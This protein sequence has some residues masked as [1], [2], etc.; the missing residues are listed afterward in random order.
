MK[1]LYTISAL[2][3][4]SLVLSVN[5]LAAYT[6]AIFPTA[7]ESAATYFTF[8][9]AGT[10]V[11]D[12]MIAY[13]EVT[14]TW[15]NYSFYVGEDNQKTAVSKVQPL[16][17]LGTSASGLFSVNIYTT[18]TY[19]D[20]YYPHSF[21][22]LD[23]T[24][25]IYG[26]ACWI[27]PITEGCVAGQA[28]SAASHIFTGSGAFFK[29]EFVVNE[30]TATFKVLKSADG[31]TWVWD[32]GQ[33]GHPSSGTVLKVGEGLKG[34]GSS[35][36]SLNIPG[37]KSGD[38]VELQLSKDGAIYTLKAYY[39]P[40]PVITQ[41]GDGCNTII[42]KLG[43]YDQTEFTPTFTLNGTA[44]TFT[45]NQ[46][47]V[48]NPVRGKQ[49]TVSGYFTDE[50]GWK[51]E[52]ATL[53][54]M[55]PEQV[56]KPVVEVS[57]DACNVAPVFTLKNP[58][59]GVTYT[60]KLN[61]SVVT[62][63]DNQY[64]VVSPIAGTIYSMEVT[65]TDGC[66]QT[67]SD[68]VSRTYKAAPGAPVVS[69][70]FGCDAPIVFTVTNYDSQN[71]Y[72]WKV[73]NSLVSVSGNSYTVPSPV[74][75]TKY[76]ADVI[77]SK[78]GCDSPSGLA[79]NAYI[80]TPVKPELSTNDGC[81]NDVIFTLTNPDS[82]STY[83]WVSGGVVIP[84]SGNS[85]TVPNPVDGENYT[86]NVTAA[87]SFD[88]FG[89]CPSVKET[90]SQVY[91]AIPA[92]PDVTAYRECATTGTGSWS[93]LVTLKSKHTAVWYD[94]ESSST[95]IPQPADYDKSDVGV[96]SYWV[97]QKSQSGCVS[98]RSKVSVEVLE[99]PVNP[100]TSM[101][102]NCQKEGTQ[103][104]ASLVSATGTLHWYET[105][106][107]TTEIADPGNFDTNVPQTTTYYVTQ[108]NNNGC[109]S[110]KSAVVVVVRQNPAAPKVTDYIA[111]QE[112]G[113]GK[114]A[115]LVK[116][117]QYLTLRWYESET[118]T[119]Y[120]PTANVP[121]FNKNVVGVRSY[122]VSSVS[123][124]GSCESAR[125]KVTVDV[126]Q[127]PSVYAG[128]NRSICYGT[129]TQ[130]GEEVLSPG[131]VKYSWEPV[132]LIV[133][134]TVSNPVT[135][136]LTNTTTFTVTAY[137]QSL[138]TCYATSSVTVTVVEN[139]VADL[140]S[141]S[142]P[143]CPGTSTTF[144]NKATESD[145]SYSWTPTDKIQGSTTGSS[146]ITKSLTETTEFTLTASRKLY[147]SL[148][149]SS[150][151]C[152]STVTGKAYIVEAPEAFAGDDAKVCIGAVHRLGKAGELNVVY[153]WTPA[154]KVDYPNI[155]NPN[156]V[157]VTEDIEYTLTATLAAAPYCSSTDQVKI[158]KVEK[159]NKYVVSG[160]NNYCSSESTAAMIIT[161]SESDMNTE[162]ALFRD[163]VMVKD[164]Q[165]GTGGSFKW[166]DN[167]A[168]VYTVKARIIGTNC[169]EDMDGK[170][171]II[172][173]QSPTATVVNKGVV[174]CPGETTTIQVVFQGDAPF[175]YK[176]SENGVVNHTGTT[177]SQVYE[178]ELTPVGNTVIKVES[179]EDAY[180]KNTFS[181]GD[182]PKLELDIEALADFKI[183][184]TQSASVVCPGDKI[185]LYIDY[186]GGTTHYQWSTGVIDEPSIDVSPT[187]TSQYK[188]YAE[189]ET[190]CIL[191][192]SITV[193]VASKDAFKIEGLRDTRNYCSSETN[194]QITG[195]PTG[196]V[197]SSNKPCI[198]KGT[199]TLDFS[200]VDKSQEVTLT[201]TYGQQGCVFD[202]T[203][204]LHVSAVLTEV[205]WMVVP[206]FGP[207][208][209][210]D[211]TY[212]LKTNEEE[213]N[214]K[215]PLQGYPQQKNGTWKVE[216]NPQTG[217]SSS[218]K[219]IVTDP[220][221][222]QANLV[223]VS[224]G[225]YFITYYVKDEFGCEASKTKNLIIRKDVQEL[226]DM[227]GFVYD[228][229]DIVCNKS[230]S[231]IIKAD[232]ITGTYSMNPS[233]AINE[234]KD[235]V[236]DFN[237]SAFSQG[238]NSAIYTILDNKGCPHRYSAP[239]TV[240]A[241]VNV[242]VNTSKNSYCSYDA[243]DPIT[244]ESLTP[245]TGLISIYRCASG[246][247]CSDDNN[248][249]LVESQIPVFS[250]PQFR[251]TWGS[252]EY[253]I[254]YAYDDGNC[255][256]IAKR[257]VNVYDPTPISM[258]MNYDY[259]KGDVIKLGATPTGGFYT[260]PDA[261]EG[262]II[263]TTFY[264]EKSGLGQFTLT[265]EVIN[266]YQCVSQDT[267]QIL[268]RGTDNL[269][270]F[271]LPD[272]VCSP[273]GSIEIFGFP[274]PEN[275]DSVYFTGPSFLHGHTTPRDSLEYATIDLSKANF[276][277][278]YN[279][280]YNYVQAYIDSLSQ[281][282][283]TCLSTVTE[284]FKV[285]NEASDFGGYEHLSYLCGDKDY[286]EIAANHT[287]N[288]DFIF[289]DVI[290]HPDAF[291]DNGD[292]TGVIYP[293]KL[294]EGMYS[295]TMYHYLVEE[296]QECTDPDDP[297]TCV[298]VYDTVCSTSKAK[299]FYIER[300]LDIPEIGLYCNNG[301]N[302]VKMD[303]TE[304]DVK[305]TLFVNNNYFEEQTGDGGPIYYGE[306]PLDIANC[307]I[308]AYANGC[309]YAM[310]KV[311][312]VEKLKMEHTTKNISCN[313]QIDGQFQATVTGGR[314]PYYHVISDKA[315]SAIVVKDSVDLHLGPQEYTY[316]ITDSVGCVRTTDF[317]ITQPDV[318]TVTI[319]KQD[320]NCTGTSTGILRAMPDGGSIPYTY[321]WVDKATGTVVGTDA[322]LVDVPSGDYQVNIT[323]NNGC[324]A[325][326]TETL[327]APVPLKVKVTNVV[328]VAVIG[329]AT[330][331]IDIVASDGTPTATGE[332]FYKWTGKSITPAT[333]AQQNQTDLLAGNY[334]VT[335]TDDRGCEVSTSA[336][337]TEPTPYV[338]SANIKNVS[339]N[340]GS[341]GYI[342]MNISGVQAP[343][344]YT[345]TINGGQVVGTSKDLLN[346][347]ADIYHL[348]VEDALGNKYENDYQV[349]EPDV[350]QVA[351]TITSNFTE[352]C[353]GDKTANID[354]AI[355][356]GTLPYNVTW[357]GVAPEQITDSAHV[358][359]LAAGTYQVDIVDA[360][361]C[362]TSLS[363][364][365]T[366]PAA[367]LAIASAVVKDLVCY[368][369]ADG[370]IDIEVQ[371]GTAPYTYL[372]TGPGVDPVAEDQT[373]L[374]GGHFGVKITD[375][376]GC[377]IGREFDVFEPSEL[378]VDAYG[379]SLAC[380][381][382][383]KGKV[384]NI[385]EGGV[386]PYSFIW[387]NSAST[388]ISTD[389][390]VISLPAETYTV[391]VTDK[392]GCV[393]HSTTILTQ[394]TELTATTDFTNIQ[395]NGAA[396]GKV[397]VTP[398]GGTEAYKYAWYKLPDETIA[399]S[400][401]SAVTNLEPGSYRA[402]VTDANG[403]SLQTNVLTLTE[404]DALKINYTVDDVAVHGEATGVINASTTGG[405][406]PVEYTWTA[407]PSID[408]TNRHNQT[409]TGIL[410]GNYYLDVKDANGCTNSEMIVVN[411]PEALDVT[412]VVEN[413][414]CN[415]SSTGAIVVSVEGGDGNYSYTWTSDKGYTATTKDIVGVPAD[416]YYVTVT[417][418][419]GATVNKE[420]D[421]TEPDLLKS[422]MVT[423]GTNLTVK[424][425][426]EK[427]AT[428]K[429][430]FSGGTAPYKVTWNGPD[431]PASVAD[432]SFVS[433]LGTG[434][435]TMK[436]EDANGCVE[437]TFSQTVTGPA[438]PLAIDGVVVNNKCAEE[439][440]GSIT[441]TV[442]GGTAPYTYSWTG[443]EGLVPGAKDQTTLK[444]GET[445]RV[446][447]T[448]ANGCTESKVF[449]LDARQQL[450][451]ALEATMV[452]C[453]GDHDGSLKAQVAG[454]TGAYS[455]EWVNSAGTWKDTNLEAGNMPA[456]TYTFTVKDEAGCE[457]SG[458][459]D[460][461][462]PNP[463]SVTVTS[464]SVLCNGL[465]DG[466]A[467]AEVPDGA[468]TKPY[469][470]TWYKGTSEYAQ[471]AKITNLGEGVYKVVVEDKNGC[472]AS[473]NT[474]INSS[475]P[476]V[477]TLD[478]KEDVQIHGQATGLIELTVTGGTQPLYYQWS[479]IGI[480]PAHQND[481][482]QYNLIAG[483]YYFTVT[484]YYSC[485]KDL[486]VEIYQPETMIV[487]S[488][489]KY[490]DCYG[491]KGYI[492][493]SVTGGYAPYTCSWTSESGTFTSSDL[494]I[495]NLDPDTYKVEIRDQ[496]N[497]PYSNSFIIP[498]K[499]ELRWKLL[500]SSKAELSCHGD[501]DGYLN[502]EITGGTPAYSIEWHGP[503]LYRK[504]VN[505]ISHIGAGEYTAYIKDA[506]GC[507]PAE[508]FSKLVTEPDTL[509]LTA[510]IVDNHCSGLNE[511][512][513]TLNVQGGVPD[514]TYKWSGFVTD[515]T[516]KDQTNLRGGDYH[517][518]MADKNS[519]EVDTTFYVREPDKLFATISGGDELCS[520][521]E[522]TLYFN[523]SGASPW[524]V[525]YTDGENVITT[526]F[527]E[528]FTEVKVTPTADTEYRLISATDANGCEA[529][530][531]GSVFV[532]VYIAP[533]ATVISNDNDCCLGDE[534]NVELMFSNPGPW[535]VKYSDGEHVYT[536]AT[537]TEQSSV[538]SI[539]PTKVGTT[540]Y[541]ILSV[542]NNHC[543][544]DIN[545]EFDVETYYYPNLNVE[546]PAYVCQPNPI[547]VILHPV[548]TAPWLVSYSVNGQH[549]EESVLADGQIIEFNPIRE[550]NQFIFETIQSGERCKTSLGKQ[551]NV[552]VG[553]LPLD[554]TLVTG[555]NLVCRNS[556]AN[557][558]TA[559]IGYADKYVWELPVGYSI[560][561]GAGSTDIIVAI[562]P[563]AESGEVKVY[564][565][566]SCGDGGASTMYVEVTKPITSTGEIT[567]PTYI[568]EDQKMFTLSVS[569]VT[570]ATSYE[571]ILPSGYTIESGQGTMNILVSF[572]NYA[573]SGT[574]TVVPSNACMDAEPITKYVNLRELP[575]A[576]AGIDFNTNCSTDARL[577]A[578]LASGTTATWTQISGS[579][580][581]ETPTSPTSKVM[582]L[583]FGV[584]EFRWDVTDDYCINFDTVAVT[585][586]NPGITEPEERDIVTCE[587]Q[588]LL[589]APEPQFGAGRWTL[590]AGEGTVETPDSN[591]S[592][593]TALGTKKTNVIRWEVYHGAC[594][595]QIDV[596]VTSN[597]LQKLADAGQDGVTTDGTYHLSARMINNPSI[598][599]T[600]SVVGGAG[601]I[602]N[603]NVEN[604]IV[605]GLD[606]GINTIRWTLKGY[607]CE[608]YDEVQV[609][610]V[611]EPIASYKVD[612]DADCSPF[613]VYF[614]NTTIGAA[615]Y[616]WNFGDGVTSNLR[617]VEH[618]F[619]KPG[620]YNV[621]LKA[622]G[623]KKTSEYS[624]KITVYEHPKADFTTGVQK[625]Y[626]PNADAYFYDRSTPAGS[627][628]VKWNWDFGDNTGKSTLKDPVYKYKESGQFDVS[629]LVTDQNGCMDSITY[630]KLMIVAKESFIVY[631]TAFVPNV[632]TPADGHFAE[633]DAP[634]LDIFYPVFRNV[635]TYSLK[636]YNQWG[637]QVFQSDDVLYGW[638]GW[639]QGQCA[640]QGSYVYKAEG[641]Y[642]D[643]TTFRVA[644]NI[645]L[646]R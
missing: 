605:R 232:N 355:E 190:G 432:S 281:Q 367:P 213:M 609:Q 160:D 327:V 335:V 569:E 243:D 310:S 552:N 284:T 353:F 628:I 468:G 71:T 217:A 234:Q 186:Q 142:T 319:E 262:S 516:S 118:A 250:N 145:V 77:A 273:E 359:D 269:K 378:I 29:Y 587:D 106:T 356:G 429:V 361:G 638:N 574:V 201:Y 3:L 15:S 17:D 25:Y 289:S 296:H 162:Y 132:A 640:A 133:D 43:S 113:T 4:L 563:D 288:T 632:I 80:K 169:V 596:N 404:P 465:N 32:S 168:G 608:A 88:T 518:K 131:D 392:V 413:A 58:V 556:E 287:K 2:L 546:M 473:A 405:T 33:L 236:L 440:A 386:Y 478:R 178:Y 533:T 524:D 567:A 424:C 47:Q 57:A 503:D 580:T 212:C 514:Y 316:T 387:T 637:A 344:Q 594:S 214:K 616:E 476:L 510:V 623:D 635:D 597:N 165:Q 76:V 535:T 341:D 189:T 380:F 271:D 622:T 382:S 31:S 211:Y 24:E 447:V 252:G 407:G 107:S 159:P 290:A 109:E 56:E 129:S 442:T 377:E 208:Y 69:T 336:T 256:W 34:G 137:N 9:K 14:G 636:V 550:D 135:R 179:L 28:S 460:I 333:E 320:V 350:L 364:D 249:V 532:K 343:Y 124:V 482:N 374:G 586:D 87:S 504:D 505:N 315:T 90:K 454:G 384:W 126:R 512:S 461:T 534:V 151:K 94:S 53:S 529:E 173:R 128:E 643:G 312:E 409:L 430:A 66:T 219:I 325:F 345:W 55:L 292:G 528:Q 437:N 254:E 11:P 458:S 457:K 63:T 480:D 477:I 389:S 598:K 318:L 264:T 235:G 127:K 114:W 545:Y 448:D 494:K 388:Q 192:D 70:T 227:K 479:G 163:G 96:K 619:E 520:G 314:M 554:A 348:Y 285:L 561:S 270:I 123:S 338:V 185:K 36:C 600:W 564:G 41:I 161:L 337:V 278:T 10:N 418:G 469:K 340:G 111:C 74:N 549:Y 607:D 122:W 110:A 251:P 257:Y 293:K 548:G 258:N 247:D 116:N 27:A 255:E 158:T 195:Y 304:V 200:C 492:E 547:E 417:D 266:Q 202:T 79:E 544:S 526:Q 183:H 434:T 99:L 557:F 450:D 301:N 611:D 65:A 385:T 629:L 495:Y 595:N 147:P 39:I 67:T 309:R 499:E 92:A 570:G 602:D 456:D 354:I 286:V 352:A 244:V 282:P 398:Q 313:G 294:P 412:A 474:I 481:L 446:E 581:I 283:A 372:W 231:A 19:D 253:R 390:I 428:I 582:D 97:A 604:T 117:S 578:K 40:T 466:E 427:S 130:L 393:R 276:S 542:E 64:T 560:V 347:K 152:I 143:I 59:A 539:T 490:I 48:T 272:R 401:E 326:A 626:L 358:K 487:T 177:D 522:F 246:V 559:Y 349:T 381:E 357:I 453:S 175:K 531:S 6:I 472:T 536:S 566:N 452:S 433:N 95:E 543:S 633:G 233:S 26:M 85:Y 375:A 49:Y 483:K 16:T 298:T 484:D 369:D 399:I 224:A 408:D 562:G 209:Q 171:T 331:A 215:Y 606:P 18:H 322:T 391:E 167:P 436:V 639:F 416:R 576:E 396:D 489:V 590:I 555:P 553:M 12:E 155:A 259:C 241:P 86:M 400:V 394:P 621:R 1:K 438:A 565:N 295:I 62:P 157:P 229:S 220:T 342:Y 328:D 68:L 540:H 425:Y 261:P 585:N 138:S 267:T 486:M 187:A 365:I 104:F 180:C 230:V 627:A 523:M 383:G 42:F 297:T 274:A 299:S 449:T 620:V 182:N 35:D 21:K 83:T 203:I 521:E 439:Q 164:Y 644:G 411:Q 610:S 431:I 196:G 78:F 588:V 216:A 641:R 279:V 485:T 421:V 150:E 176:I 631:P 194:V 443:G 589:R 368:G 265:Y 134:P 467:Y 170:A 551:L 541:T 300:L 599:G 198:L 592:L 61:G 444:S 222:S 579:G 119:S 30:V 642:K 323:D 538:L 54:S 527:T 112:E 154:D 422:E 498:A 491:D 324:T 366:Q 558:H 188:I 509:T 275:N 339:C 371:G 7:D 584:N 146:I 238:G 199:N 105:S 51:S 228:P 475:E 403:C 73:N 508:Q 205:D 410:A 226:V 502:L 52:V 515:P 221:K 601:T 93:A 645:T 426:G 577:N 329:E 493:L 618:T 242:I 500:E 414:K 571:W 488:N 239:F 144:E 517:L 248:W 115:D 44:I 260:A 153:S 363:Q 362:Q 280:S 317:T 120:I 37:I 634:R 121:D 206:D 321:E 263:N 237:P 435:Y 277:T 240:V 462:E 156:T 463:M 225:T 593:V 174:A 20:N 360:L 420:Y 207:P 415:G 38:K 575:I 100:Y 8:E 591:E 379:T 397:S 291:V 370:S 573:K 139:P 308:E 464:S 406:E 148:P 103:S 507:V 311:I 102:S 471:G 108:S 614:Y 506:K 423:S 72:T 513:I 191:Q 75:H 89:P 125:T 351:T 330:G 630:Q 172:A 395:C 332:Y 306:I 455:P 612:K 136:N 84:V 166:Y 23:D 245:T 497:N 445:Y 568:C 13:C 98:P 525:S 459:I 140:V 624:S 5:A 307:K 603:P 441:L 82:Y 218:A 402:T 530:V 46:Y 50:D 91:M 81:G 60:W 615:E 613:T 149:S 181:S 184:S 373:N 572:N 210:K 519:C 537:F 617:S 419:L 204:V 646:I 496:Q 451:I 22:A 376:N 193:V 334:Y 625:L 141:A 305:Y 197:F 45:S 470:Y 101:Y 511:G 268:V 302:A 583:L 223:D 501:K 346:I 303:K